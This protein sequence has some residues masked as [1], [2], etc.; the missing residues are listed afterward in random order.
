MAKGEKTPKK[1]AK[2][3]AKKLNKS[4]VTEAVG[5]LLEAQALMSRAMGHI[6]AAANVM[7]VELEL[8]LDTA[9]MTA[10]ESQHHT[11][12]AAPLKRG[13]VPDPANGS[14]FAA[15]ELGNPGVFTRQVLSS[16]LSNLGG[17]PVGKMP[18]ALRTAIMEAQGGR[19]TLGDCEFTGDFDVPTIT[20]AYGGGTY[21]CGPKVAE[22]LSGKSGTK[23][24]KIMQKL[25][26]GEIEV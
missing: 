7:N 8:G 26:D 21:S 16:I 25:I 18:P 14:E 9:G 2:K 1:S 23:F 11:R 20:V 12:P 13:A 17:D 5:S 3:S 4:A 6:K 15:E 19:E 10:H 22:L 24:D